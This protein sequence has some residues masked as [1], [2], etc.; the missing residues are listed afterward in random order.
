MYRIKRADLGAVALFMVI[1]AIGAWTPAPRTR[2]QGVC[3]PSD[4]YSAYLVE[5]IELMM[6][7]A[8][9][10]DLRD[11]LGLS[12]MSSPSVTR[13]GSDSLCDLAGRAINRTQGL[14]ETGSRNVYLVKI[15]AQRYWAEDPDIGFGEYT[16]V[17]V[18]DSTV[19]NVLG[20]TGH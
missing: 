13:V 3:A 9:D 12:G 19:S 10:Q 17:F 20:T 8:S 2:L 7:N 6:A 11:S 15:G 18:L 1:L 4:Q 5:E 16:K 14:A